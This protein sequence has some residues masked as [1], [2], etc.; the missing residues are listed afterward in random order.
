MKHEQ[1]SMRGGNQDL[2]RAGHDRPANRST[3]FFGGATAPTERLVATL[4]IV[5]M[6]R[7]HPVHFTDPAPFRLLMASV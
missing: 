4:G 2:N 6:L 5:E 7:E 1:I 3:C